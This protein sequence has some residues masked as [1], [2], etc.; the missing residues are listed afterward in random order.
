M[1]LSGGIGGAKLA[2]G[3]AGVMD[4][5]RLVIVANTGD[6]FEHL[7]L[8]VCPDIDTLIYTLAGV[9]NPETG[10][11]RADETWTFMDELRER[12][13]DKA[14]FALGDKDLEVHRSRKKQLEDGATLA[15]VTAS[16]ARGFG[17]RPTILPMSNDPVRTHLLAEDDDQAQWLGFQEYFVRYRCVPRVQRIDYRGSTQS[18]P[19]PELRELLEEGAVQAIVICP[20]NPYLSIDPILSVTG[21]ADLLRRCGAPV[22]AV[23]PIVGGHALKGPTAKIMREFD[24]ECTV[25]AIAQHY[26]G[27]LDGLVIDEQDRDFAQQ[28]E[29]GGLRSPVTNTVMKTLEDR[30]QLARDVLEFADRIARREGDVGR[31]TR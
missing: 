27:L 10:W 15:E 29:A 16:I 7:G 30:R 19:T 20:S 18:S 24:I 31:R 25:A 26:G 23:S 2:Q 22:V 4:P 9:S 6:D 5:E 13:P 12:D 3:L 8:T 1:A 17:V 14:W 28:L 11:G 21:M